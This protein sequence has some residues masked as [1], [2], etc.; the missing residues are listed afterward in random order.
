[1]WGHK[2]GVLESTSSLIGRKGEKHS[3]RIFCIQAIHRPSLIRFFSFFKD[4]H[5]YLLFCLFVCFLGGGL[6]LWHMEIS[7]LGWNWSCSCWP[8]VTATA[9]ATLDPSCVC[10]PYHSSRQH[11]ILNPL[12]EARDQTCPLTDARWFH[13]S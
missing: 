5:Y 11:W 8:T 6:H 3:M 10:N 1:M 7:R 2:P 9:T 13:Y 12:S 4:R